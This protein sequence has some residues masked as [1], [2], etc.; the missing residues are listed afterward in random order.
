MPLKEQYKPFCPQVSSEIRD[1]C[2]AYIIDYKIHHIFLPCCVYISKKIFPAAYGDIMVGKGNATVEYLSM[3]FCSIQQEGYWVGRWLW[4]GL[5]RILC[6]LKEGEKEIKYL[7]I[8]SLACRMG[9]FN[10]TIHSTWSEWDLKRRVHGILVRWLYVLNIR[11][12]HAIC[13]ER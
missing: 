7:Y 5:F 9:R 4:N 11:G 13:R 12:K 2:I 6:L 1:S 3:R 10:F 8:S